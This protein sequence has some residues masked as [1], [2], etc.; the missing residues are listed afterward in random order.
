LEDILRDVSRKRQYWM[1]QLGW[2]SVRL[3]YKLLL[4]ESDHHLHFSHAAIQLLAVYCGHMPLR[5]HALM[6]A[7]RETIRSAQVE[8]RNALT[9]RFYEGVRMEGLE[10]SL[11]RLLREDPSR[12]VEKTVKEAF[13]QES[14]LPKTGRMED[15]E[16]LCFE[17]CTALL[18]AAAD[19]MSGNSEEQGTSSN[20]AG[21]DQEA[22]RQSE[23]K[24]R[25]RQTE[26]EE[27]PDGKKRK[28]AGAK[29]E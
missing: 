28:H 16:T 2:K 18:Q 15:V 7:L 22:E 21:Q 11:R 20:G 25:R 27:H 14:R 5:W 8:L 13:Y 26:E 3:C 9:R 10:R 23:A 6:W 17:S 12:D 19:E 1:I 29:K 24:G 4:N